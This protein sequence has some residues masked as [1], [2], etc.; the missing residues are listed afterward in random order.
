MDSEMLPLASLLFNGY[1]PIQPKR[2][3]SGSRLPVKEEN[4]TEKTSWIRLHDLPKT[5]QMALA[6]VIMKKK[7]IGRTSIEVSQLGLGCAT[8]G[9]EIDEVE[10]HQ[11]MDFAVE[12]GITLFDTAESYG[13]GEAR[14]YRR[15]TYGIDDVR[16]V[17]SEMHSSE[18]IIGRWLS[19]RGCRNQI[20]LET[21]VSPPFTSSALRQKIEGSLERLQTDWIDLYLFHSPDRTT[22]M[23][24]S[25]EVVTE[26]IKQGKIRAAGCSNFD[27]DQVRAALEISDCKQLAR[28]EVIQ[29]VYNLVARDLEQELLSLS[30][31]KEIGVISYS[32]LGAG[33]LTGKYGPDRSALPAG[34]R[35]HV[36]PGHAD[37]YFSDR[38]FRIVERLRQKAAQTGF[39]M[40]HLAMAWVAHKMGVTSVLVGARKPRHLQNAVVALEKH[41]SAAWMKEMD[42][43]TDQLF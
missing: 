39:S 40:A 25:L 17:S 12:L 27:A 36:I 33:F 5:S 29:P 2:N 7:R 34:T 32:P 23:E 30:K 35:F 21:K 26:A 11:I 43:W 4:A 10:S 28:L 3:L 37:I 41:F 18:K 24:E 15:R 42:S 1:N 38:N 16:E 22:P 19:S 13:G 9:R 6:G 14:D 20:V 31:L 8:F